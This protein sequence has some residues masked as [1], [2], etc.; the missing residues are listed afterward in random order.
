MSTLETT[1]I[2]AVCIAGLALVWRVWRWWAGRKANNLIKQQAELCTEL[3]KT[4]R[5]SCQLIVANNGQA[6]ARNV[7]ITLDGSPI[8]E[9]PAVPGGQQEVR[10]IGPKSYI[11]YI[12]AFSTECHPPFKLEATW[13]DDSSQQGR[14]E[15]TLI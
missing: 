5:G 1:A 13:D 15:T 14:Y 7:T 9:H 2:V 8:L 3:R 11:P 12:M 10:L 4:D 6:T